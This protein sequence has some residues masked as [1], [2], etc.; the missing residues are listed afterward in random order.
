ARQLLAFDELERRT[1]AGGDVIDALDHLFTRELDRRRAVAAADDGEAADLGQRARDGERALGERLRLEEAHRAVPEH[2]LGA[3]E[4]FFYE[5]DR[6]G[7][8]VERHL[9]GG[10]RGRLDRLT[11][12]RVDAVGH[13][14]IDRQDE[15]D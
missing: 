3:D 9:A 2:R 13:D 11:R 6:L 4:L 5:R 14:E 10:N 8:D 7:A 15:P 12:G 1:A